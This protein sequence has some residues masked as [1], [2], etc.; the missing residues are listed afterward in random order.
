MRLTLIILLLIISNR[1]TPAAA[2]DAPP[3]AGEIDAWVVELGAERFTKRDAATKK[4]IESG[5]AAIEPLMKGIAL[6]GLEVTTR[7]IYVLQQL[8]VAG[9]EATE[10][11]AR[12]SLEQLAAARVTA[13]ARHA[14]DALDKLDAL[15]QQR[16][17]DKLQQLGAVVARNHQELSSTMGPL[18]AIE[19]H[20]DWRG[21]TDDLRWLKYLHDVQQISFIG[22]KVNDEW[23]PHLAGMPNMLLVKIKR[24]NITEAGLAPLKTL[25]RLEFIRL[26]YMDI[27]DDAIV[28]LARCQHAARI[29]LFGT[30]I[31]RDGEAKL[32]ESLGARVELKRGAFLGIAPT[33]IDNATWEIGLVTPGTAA[34][35]AGLRVGDLVVTYDTKKVGDFLSLNA[36]IAEHDAGQ[37]VDVTLR[38]N[39]EIIERRIKLGEWD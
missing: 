23:L 36:M 25:A 20:G 9:D 5:I 3:T 7:G 29:D 6:H 15:R 31:T 34:D 13:A 10:S 21:T 17:L 35:K 37:V 11:K 26:M 33:Q 28:H 22:P 38:R 19:I 12:E 39:G 14:R 24:A 30:K 4:L 1:G 18:F 2:Q 8:A 16:A 32:R 27:G